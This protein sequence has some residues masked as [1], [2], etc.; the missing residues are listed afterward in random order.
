MA[1][2]RLRP[3]ATQSAER[4]APPQR[5]ASLRRPPSWPS[6]S[7]HHQ[8]DGKPIER[9]GSFSGRPKRSQRRDALVGDVPHRHHV[10]VPDQHPVERP[11]G[12]DQAV[13]VRREDDRVDQLVDGRVLDADVDCGCRCARPPRCP[14][15]RAA[16]CRATATAPSC[17]PPCRSRSSAR[18]ART[19]R[20]RWCG[21]STPTPSSFELLAGREAR[22]ARTAA[23]P[24]GIRRVSSSPLSLLAARLAAVLG[25]VQPASVEQLRAPRAGS[26]AG[27]AACRSPGWRIRR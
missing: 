23:S 16:R 12:G 20:C 5:Y 11:A 8:I 3:Q 27:S 26:C 9:S 4:R 1:A 17:R 24:A 25:D 6:S 18:G 21:P 10:V 19:A 13:A 22:C 15:S 14:R 7:S 2:V